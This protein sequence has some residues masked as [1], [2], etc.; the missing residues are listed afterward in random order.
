MNNESSSQ[1]HLHGQRWGLTAVIIPAHTD[2]LV[3]AKARPTSSRLAAVNTIGG[4][5]RCG[6]VPLSKRMNERNFCAPST[7]P[8]T[9][10]APSLAKSSCNELNAALYV[11]GGESA[12]KRLW[13]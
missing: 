12:I 13:Q 1:K 4:G 11:A 7:T 2:T 5:Q 3:P 9:V 6:V 8:L 10:F